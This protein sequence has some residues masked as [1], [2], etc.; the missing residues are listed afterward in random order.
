MIFSVLSLLTKFLRST[1]DILSSLTY[2]SKQVSDFIP[3][4]DIYNDGFCKIQSL[5]NTDEQLA[6]VSSL[7]EGPFYCNSDIRNV[8]TFARLCDYLR[9]RV[10][11]YDYKPEILESYDYLRCPPELAYTISDRALKFLQSRLKQIYTVD[12]IE[13]YRTRS[14]GTHMFNSNWH[15]DGDC[16]ASIRCLLYLS[17][18]TNLN[19]GPLLLQTDGDNVFTFLG[20]AGDACF[21]R[22]SRIL[23]K[24]AHTQKDRLCLNIKFRPAIFNTRI[25]RRVYP[26]NYQGSIV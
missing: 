14:D 5:V 16:N 17:D 22:N 13:M 26:V 10:Y 6:L 20:N 25:K 1:R 4:G 7:Y 15:V 23:H 12:T 9:N 11:W 3:E 21:F 2:R 8:G 19:D 24:G 18:V